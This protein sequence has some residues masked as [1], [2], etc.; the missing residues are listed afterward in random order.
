MERRSKELQ[1]MLSV[2]DPAGPL[3]FTEE[4]SCLRS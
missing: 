4:S 3:L 2:G 1:A